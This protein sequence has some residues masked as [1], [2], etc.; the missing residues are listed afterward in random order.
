MKS[1]RNGCRLRK[2]RAPV[3]G[4]LTNRHSIVRKKSPCFLLSSPST[5]CEGFNDFLDCSHQFWINFWAFHLS[6][7]IS[8]FAFFLWSFNR[9]FISLIDPFLIKRAFPVLTRRITHST[10]N[11]IWRAITFSKKYHTKHFRFPWLRFFLDKSKAYVI[12]E[13]E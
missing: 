9:S 1:G 7:K 3:S 5:F 10:K 8:Y 11:K 13:R 12:K 2:K 4:C 6:G